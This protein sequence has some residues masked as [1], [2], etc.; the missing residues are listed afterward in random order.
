M[1][2]LPKNKQLGVISGAP[3]TVLSGD[4]WTALD[5]DTRFLQMLFQCC[6]PRLEMS[7]APHRFGMDLLAH[8]DVAGSGAGRVVA[9]EMET[10][11]FE[12]SPKFCERFMAKKPR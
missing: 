10:R 7:P 12:R 5:S 3:G 11:R 9:V 6:K 1:R 8:L 4:G 2:F